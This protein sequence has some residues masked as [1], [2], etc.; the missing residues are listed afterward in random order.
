MR[1]FCDRSAETPHVFTSRL[2]DGWLCS[3]FAAS[4]VGRV[5]VVIRAVR[6]SEVVQLVFFGSSAKKVPPIDAHNDS[7]GY[8]HF[9]S[10][11]P[12]GLPLILNREP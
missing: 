9:G 4:V 2:N 10:P 12:P 8:L 11:F 1:A 3:C 7:L 5:I 6:S